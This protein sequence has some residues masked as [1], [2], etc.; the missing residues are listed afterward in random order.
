MFRNVR[1]NHRRINNLT[2]NQIF[3]DQTTRTD[4]FRTSPAE[5]SATRIKMPIPF[6]PAGYSEDVW[7][8]VR[9]LFN[10]QF[11]VDAKTPK[12]V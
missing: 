7:R 5:D 12:L 3:I 1:I 4:K 8:R 6:P 10:G 9:V 11:V 2:K